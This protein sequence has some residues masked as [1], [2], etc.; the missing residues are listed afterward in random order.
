MSPKGVFEQPSSLK[1]NKT[2][3]PTPGDMDDMRDN[4]PN[5]DN[6]I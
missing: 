2:Q 3:P 1:E 4:S 6:L 5:L